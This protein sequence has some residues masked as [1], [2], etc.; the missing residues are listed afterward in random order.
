M[1]SLVIRD[2]VVHSN[3]ETYQTN[4]DTIVPFIRELKRDMANLFDYEKDWEY[5][6]EY[7]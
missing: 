3:V 6:W 5:I 1:N 7:I 4:Q 2:H